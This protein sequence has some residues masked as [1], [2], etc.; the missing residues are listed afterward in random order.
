MRFVSFEYRGQA[1]YGLWKDEN[2]WLQVPAAFA[3]QYPDL[4]S[5]IA[6]NQLDALEAAALQAG[7]PVKAS[8]AQL[9]PVIAN[10]GKVF[11]VGLNYKTHVAEM[12]R[13]DSEHPAIFTRFADSLS[14][15][16]APLPK[17]ANVARGSLWRE[18]ERRYEAYKDRVVT[19]FFRDHFSRLDRQIVLVDALQA[20]NRGPEAVQDLER[21]LGDV[22]A[23]FRAGSNNMLTSLVRRRIDRV[24]VAVS[25][26]DRFLSVDDPH[27]QLARVG[28]STRA[29]SVFNGLQALLDSG[30]DDS[31]W[32]L[33]HDAARCL[34]TPAQVDALIDACLADAVGGLLAL[35]LPDTLKVETAGRVAAT[36]DRSDKWLAQTPQMFRLGMLRSA[37]AAQADSGFAGVTDEASAME[38]A[39]HPPRLVP[40]SAR[41]FKVTWPD[42]F[43]LAEAILRT[44]T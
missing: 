23:C 15:H 26:G 10:P 39:G 8:D 32:V 9:L 12:K 4:K 16:G 7:E 35:K 20:L 19:P 13:A 21:A 33:V 40:G 14:A 41:N 22:L 38:M 31:D 29:A 36:V 3:A 37:L 2:N 24:L 28:G 17:P 25:P 18:M 42:D 44:P 6:A 43:D 27:I 1:S 34:I 30:A 5:V 11:C